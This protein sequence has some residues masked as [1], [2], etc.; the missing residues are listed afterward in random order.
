MN[1][2]IAN[3][4]LQLAY[5]VRRDKN[6]GKNILQLVC[7]LERTVK[8]EGS[9]KSQSTRSPLSSNGQGRQK[10][11][12]DIEVIPFQLSPVDKICKGAEIL[13]ED[14]LFCNQTEEAA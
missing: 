5:E 1:N 9:T 12:F 4:I 14:D 3:L 6:I 2:H 7:Q 11:G 13:I 10:E 8:L